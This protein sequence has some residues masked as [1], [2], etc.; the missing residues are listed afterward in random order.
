MPRVPTSDMDLNSTVTEMWDSAISPNTKLVYDSGM[1]NYRKFLSTVGE[2]SYSLT[3]PITD[4]LLIKFI[5]YCF[6]YVKIKYS[7]IKLYLCG[8]RFFYLRLGKESPLESTQKSVRI[9][10]FLKS[11]KRSQPQDKRERM[12]INIEILKHIVLYLKKGCFGKYVDKLMIS[13]CTAA[14][15]GFLR[16][17]EFTVNTDIQDQA[18][19]R[20]ED[21]AVDSVK[22]VLHLRQSKTDPFRKGINIHLHATRNQVCPVLALQEYLL[23]RVVKQSSA[24]FVMEDGCP[25]SRKVFVANLKFVLQRIGMDDSKFNG[26]SLRIGAATTCAKLRME[27]HLIKTLGRWSSDCYN[28][29]IHTDQATIKDAHVSM[30]L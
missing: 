13:A 9:H 23:L 18:Q 20:I 14:F 22:V 21:V 4:D 3:P 25:L 29:Y 19:L 6:K 26:H 17:G 24:L 2:E 1:A 27:D 10:S 8:I 16:C 28:R 5:A 12:P 11:V 30:S 15:F 7:T